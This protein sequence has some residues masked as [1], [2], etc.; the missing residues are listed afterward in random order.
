MKYKATKTFLHDQ[1]GQVHAGDVVEMTAIQ[2]VSPLL[3]GW[4]HPAEDA[5]AVQSEE[6]PAP[7]RAPRKRK[8]S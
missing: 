7:K 6:Q 2:A 4:L 3:F 8:E 1:L 5:P